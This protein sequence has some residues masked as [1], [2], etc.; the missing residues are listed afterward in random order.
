LLCLWNSFLVLFV[1]YVLCLELSDP[2]HVD[3]VEWVF[4]IYAA[5]MHPVP[6]SSILLCTTHPT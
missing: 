2:M 5:G 1:L 4:I 6:P 3:V